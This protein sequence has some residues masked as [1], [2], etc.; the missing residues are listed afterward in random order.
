MI[1][2]SKTAEELAVLRTAQAMCAAARTAP[3]TRGIDHLHSMIVLEE[4]IVVLAAEMERLSETFDYAFFMRDAQNVKHSGA[5][6]LLGY[7]Y[8]RN[9]LGAGCG[10][11]NFNDCVACEKANG[12]CVYNPIDLGIATGSAVGVAADARVDCRVMFSVG[13]AA[14]SLG[15][16]DESVKCAVGIPL[17]VMGKSPYFD[18]K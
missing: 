7:S 5:V 8:H 3:K 17:S 10:Y 18:R 14:L 4:D 11:C 9:G 16:F 2:D 1:Q 6:V 13:R 12:V 15:L